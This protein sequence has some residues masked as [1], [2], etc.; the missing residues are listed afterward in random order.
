LPLVA[1]GG[2][3]ITPARS[4]EVRSARVGY[5]S[6]SPVRVGVTT[7]D[8]TLGILGKPNYSTQHDA[9]MGYLFAVKTGT[10]RGLL[11]GPCTP[12]IGSADVYDDDDVWLEFDGQGVLKRVEKQLIK[13][14]HHDMEA[15]WRAFAK[16]VPDPIRPEQMLNGRP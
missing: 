4:P 2:C 8:T 14:H 6:G 12:Y 3:V 16:S 11:V 9:A 10:A 13:R 7:R 5:D 1:L 15:A